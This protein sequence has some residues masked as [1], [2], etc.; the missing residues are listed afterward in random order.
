MLL[1]LL[2][3]ELLQHF[4]VYHGFSSISKSK[5]RKQVTL[6]FSNKIYNNDFGDLLPL[7]TCN[8]LGLSIIIV[9]TLAQRLSDCIVK[10]NLIRSA[11]YELFPYFVAHLNNKIYSSTKPLSAYRRLATMTTSTGLPTSSSTST[12]SC[13]Y[14]MS[15]SPKYAMPRLSSQYA[16]STATPK[17]Q[18]EPAKVNALVAHT[19]PSLSTAAAT[20]TSILSS[21]HEKA[22]V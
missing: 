16:V 15:T 8:A 5:L 13:Q 19:M 9:S 11:R 18:H 22:T 21:S 1:P 3:N 14:V 7:I 6:Y 20:K 12:S 17:I 4:Y 10:P 2:S